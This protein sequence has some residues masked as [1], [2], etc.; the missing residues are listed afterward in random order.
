MIRMSRIQLIALIFM[1]ALVVLLVPRKEGAKGKDPKDTKA[2]DKKEDKVVA[3]PVSNGAC[4]NSVKAEG[5][6]GAGPKLDPARCKGLTIGSGNA[7][8]SSDGKKWSVSSSKNCK[9]WVKLANWKSP[10]NKNVVGRYPVMDGFKR[11]SGR[12]DGTALNDGQAFTDVKS[13]IDACD[14]N[15][16][17]VAVT[18]KKATASQG[19]QCYTKDKSD[20]T[21]DATWYSYTRTGTAPIAAMAA[22]TGLEDKDSRTVSIQS[23]ETTANAPYLTA[24][25]ANLYGKKTNTGNDTKWIWESG[26]GYYS[27]INVDKKNIG[28][29]DTYLG[30]IDGER[31]CDSPLVTQGKKDYNGQWRLVPSDAKDGAWKLQNRWCAEQPGGA[32]WSYL[33]LENTGSE[34]GGQ[35]AKLGKAAEATH[36][37]LPTIA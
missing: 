12:I 34:K 3:S 32:D 1:I 20:R 6:V 28:N 19:L 5:A 30:V 11:E 4:Y 26:K 15:S 21:K 18:M 37:Y 31:A 35:N 7:C 9:S 8:Y 27:F 23:S 14:S 36:F 33:R 29:G 17:C 16:A 10:N 13:C 2:K 25:G 24:S 22:L